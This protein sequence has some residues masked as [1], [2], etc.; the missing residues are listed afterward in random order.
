MSPNPPARP[1][2]D[3][4]DG[5][6]DHDRPLRRYAELTG[7]LQEAARRGFA[8]Q[9]RC[10]RG[11][12]VDPDVEQIGDAG[13][14][15]HLRKVA[16]G[17]HHRGLEP[18]LT[19]LPHPGDGPREDLHTDPL[20]LVVDERPFP[21]TQPPQTETSSGRESGVPSESSIPRAARNPRTLS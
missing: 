17:R 16:A 14:L 10:R 4:R 15:H 2:L 11:L 9:A 12:A 3:A 13:A 20:Q 7:G 19:Q 8:P 5:V 6:L 18:G 1:S 21:V